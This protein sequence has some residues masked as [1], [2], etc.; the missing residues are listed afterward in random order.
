MPYILTIKQ[1]WSLECLHLWEF[2]L[3]PTFPCSLPSFFYDVSEEDFKNSMLE[4]SQNMWVHVNMQTFSKRACDLLA[5]L[6][7]MHKFLFILT[8][9]AS[10][11]THFFKQV[12]VLNTTDHSGCD[13]H[14][15]K[16]Q[17]SPTWW[18]REISKQKKNFRKLFHRVEQLSLL[19][20]K[21]KQRGLKIDKKLGEWQ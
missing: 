12:E 13:T 8:P 7:K 6:F 19:G 9:L 18:W 16:E 2:Y 5:I 20:M 1:Y 11:L 21:K 4:M 15:Y 10:L 17:E 14:L 3:Y